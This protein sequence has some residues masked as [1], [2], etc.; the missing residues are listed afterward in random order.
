[1][2]R[3]L[4]KNYIIKQEMDLIYALHQ[5]CVYIH[6]IFFFKGKKSSISHTDMSQGACCALE[7]SSIQMPLLSTETSHKG[8]IVINIK[9]YEM[10]E[11]GW[12]IYFDFAVKV[13][14]S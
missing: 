3:I 12:T 6:M 2:D 13:W 1:M 8:T 7:F 5:C 9:H 10:L 14:I 11:E 4:T